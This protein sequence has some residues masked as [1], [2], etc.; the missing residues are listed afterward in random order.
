[1]KIL[2]IHQGTLHSLQDLGTVLFSPQTD[3]NIRMSIN[4]RWILALTPLLLSACTKPFQATTQ[5]PLSQA[6]RYEAV[7]EN[8]QLL[9]S[10]W[11]KDPLYESYENDLQAQSNL[12][13]LSQRP[14]PGSQD[15]SSSN[16]I[17]IA[18][19]GDAY[20]EAD[21]PQYE[22]DVLQ[23]IEILLNEQPMKAYENYFVFHQV[24]V[25]S[26]TNLIPSATSNK[27]NLV[28]TNT[29]LNMHFNCQGIPRLLCV[30][31]AQVARATKSISRVDAVFALANSSQYG[32]AGYLNPAVATLAARNRAASELALH[33]FGHSFGGLTD[34]YDTSGV[35]TDCNSYSNASQ[36]EKAVMQSKKSKW[37]AWLSL[38]H[39]GTFPGS[40]YTKNFFRPT[41]NSKMRSL[42]RSYEEIN[43]EQIIFKIYEKVRP[44]DSF[45][46]KLKEKIIGA[47]VFKV[48]T[49][50]PSETAMQI[51]W[52]LNEQLVKEWIG[53]Q[54]VDTADLNLKS[55][56]Y[57][58]KVVVTD[59]T[60]RVRDESKRKKLL[61]QSL[62]WKFRIKPTLF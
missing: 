17:H 15:K 3:H 51:N 9:S 6:I 45:S 52:Y 42:G 54:V 37:H 24:D 47:Q 14:L 61:S 32:G 2:G 8:G 50:Q 20:T 39:I 31:L 25:I 22:K 62:D 12:G 26:A 60:T 36:E 40:C 21:L 57:S 13:T 33:E 43:S 29:A 18:F 38:S 48:K 49:M 10:E 30:N 56:K 55:G 35:T 19:V 16:R 23:N 28:K 41:E 4:Y 46:P 1:L 5:S 59:P 53:R 44:I 7:D 34:E 11:L 58:L 27:D